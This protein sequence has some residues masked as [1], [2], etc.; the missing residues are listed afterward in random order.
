MR[1]FNCITER[2]CDGMNKILKIILRTKISLSDFRSVTYSF[3]S[4]FIVDFHASTKKPRFDL[5][6]DLTII[7]QKRKVERTRNN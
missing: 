7:N 3:H 5:Q 6:P 4:R 1:P 2:I